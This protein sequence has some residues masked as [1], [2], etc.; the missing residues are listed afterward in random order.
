[1]A[2]D[3][4]VKPHTADGSPDL[5]EDQARAY[6]AA[7]GYGGEA[8]GLVAEA[9]RFPCRYSYTKDRHRY[10]VFQMPA[11][12]WQARDCAESEERI[13]A[14]GRERRGVRGW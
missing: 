13:K 2:G 12:H 3:I 8:D 11:G 4:T 6:L 7:S 9:R 1:M 10:L 14:I 5:T